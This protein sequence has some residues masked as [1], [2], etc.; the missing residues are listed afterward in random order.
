MIE[1]NKANRRPCSRSD[2]GKAE[3]PNMI[4]MK[5]SFVIFGHKGKKLYLSAAWGLI[6]A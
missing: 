5:G 2:N 4:F 6:E 3:L 1:V